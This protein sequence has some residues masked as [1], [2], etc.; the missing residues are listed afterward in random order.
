MIDTDFGGII[1]ESNETCGIKMFTDFSN[2]LFK[3][4]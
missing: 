2:R 4:V 3:M 1:G